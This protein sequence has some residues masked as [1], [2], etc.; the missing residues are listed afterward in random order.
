MERE[1]HD[2]HNVENRRRSQYEAD[3]S[4]LEEGTQNLDHQPRSQI[5]APAQSRGTAQAGDGADDIAITTFAAMS[6][7]FRS[8]PYPDNFNLTSRSTTAAPTLA[9]GCRPTT[10]L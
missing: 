1:E 9:S 8:V 3:Y 5:V 4:H 10:S 6:P 7:R 2:R